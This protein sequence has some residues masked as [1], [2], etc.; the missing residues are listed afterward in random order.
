ML[1]SRGLTE[2]SIKWRWALDHHTIVKRCLSVSPRISN[3]M[4]DF[5]QGRGIRAS[6]QQMA[7]SGPIRVAPA[8]GTQHL[9][10][11][12][13]STDIAFAGGWFFSYYHLN[14]ASTWWP[15]VCP[16]HLAEVTW[17]SLARNMPWVAVF[18]PWL[19][20]L[21]PVSTKQFILVVFPVLR[22]PW[23][24]HSTVLWSWSWTAFCADISWQNLSI[25]V[26]T[27]SS[28]MSPCGVLIGHWLFLWHNMICLY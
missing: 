12:T 22:L 6:G 1:H 21:A 24:C 2:D 18:F 19:L 23:R 11:V 4:V 7:G 3:V 13:V 5:A 10:A 8:P 26:Y 28:E 25:K 17:R 14:S 9:A 27:M 20:R 15:P 16:V